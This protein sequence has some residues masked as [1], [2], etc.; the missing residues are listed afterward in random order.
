[1]PDELTL[2]GLEG[3]QVPT[4][5]QVQGDQPEGGVQT[6]TQESQK[7]SDHYTDDEVNQLLETDGRLDA[8]RLTPTQKLIQKSFDRHFQK[9]FQQLAEERREVAQTRPQNIFEEFDRNPG[10][11]MQVVRQAILQAKGEDPFSP[12]VSQLEALKDDL[13]YRQMTMN[14]YQTESSRVM[15]ETLSEVRR[16]L[17]NLEESKPVL[18][19]FAKSEYGFTDDDLSYLTD[20]TIHGQ[21]RVLKLIK[22]IK[23]NYELVNPGKGK[24]VKLTPNKLERVGHTTESEDKG[25]NPETWSYTK[26]KAERE[27]GR[28]K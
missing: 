9:R 5:G 26:F 27:A 3:Q 7:Q 15:T 22:F 2:Q 11:V 21:G 23:K 19:E 4:Q 8:N 20:P 16:I 18:E 28:L 24:E 6:P 12:K 1:M 13:M 17:P 14:Q 25:S 10:G